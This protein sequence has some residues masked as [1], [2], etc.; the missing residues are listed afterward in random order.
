MTV[1]TTVP[2]KIRMIIDNVVSFIGLKPF[3]NYR[4]LVGHR[5][6]YIPLRDRHV[7]HTR[8]DRFLQAGL[9]AYDGDPDRLSYGSK[10]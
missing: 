3:V 10:T 7:D 9:L 5:H 4:F 2:E 6:L 8:C 1:S